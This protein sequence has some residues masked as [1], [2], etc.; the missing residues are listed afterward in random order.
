MERAYLHIE[1]PRTEGG[2]LEAAGSLRHP[3]GRRERLW[4]RVPRAWAD[5]VTSWADP[6]IVGLLFPIMQGGRDVQVDGRVSPS[7]IANL[8]TFMGFWQEGA[9]GQYRAVHIRAREEVEAPAPAAAGQAVVPFSCGVDSCFTVFRH[10]RGLAGGHNRAITA[11]AVINGFDIWLDEDNAASMYEGLLGGARTMLD[12]VGVA[13]IPMST[14]YHDL[15]TTWK[16]SHGSH[17]A[18]GMH[19]LGARFDATMV[20]DDAPH[21]SQGRAGGD[22]PIGDPLLGREHFD[23]SS[24]GAEVLR[25]DKAAL[26]SEWP[27]AMQ[28]L[29]VCYQN[30]GSHTNCCRCQKCV[31]TILSFRVAGCPLP[32]VGKRQGDHPTT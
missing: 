20:A 7:L 32:P 19:L 13:C 3:E 22:R 27:E 28:H 2:V 23:V 14:N 1:P 6:F 5:A 26:L 31:R 18:S 21:S 11:G 30:P 4:W 12:S 9:P 16:H 24:D 29:R 10:L 25:Y 8:E 17:L 15:D